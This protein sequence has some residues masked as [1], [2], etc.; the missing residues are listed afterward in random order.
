MKKEFRFK[1]SKKVGDRFKDKDVK[2]SITARLDQ[3]VVAWL[4]QESE[5]KGIPYQTLMNS[6]LTVAMN[7]ESQELLIRKIVQEEL[8]KTG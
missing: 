7:T 2:V 5:K 4:R 3:K 1:G 8:Q 6:I